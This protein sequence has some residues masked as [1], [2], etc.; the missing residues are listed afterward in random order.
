MIP[1][2]VP[3]EEEKKIFLIKYNYSLNC[4]VKCVNKPF[5]S[6]IKITIL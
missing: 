2:K 1:T 6:K 4:L 3:G 5:N